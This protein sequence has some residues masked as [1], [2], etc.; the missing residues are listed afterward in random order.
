MN[1]YNIAAK[2]QIAIHICCC[3]NL[4][5]HTAWV[6]NHMI[7]ARVII[8]FILLSNNFSTYI[9]KPENDFNSPQ[10]SFPLREIPG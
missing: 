10:Y 7:V 3:P 6:R 9:S 5:H 1:I 8:C 4:H 2:M